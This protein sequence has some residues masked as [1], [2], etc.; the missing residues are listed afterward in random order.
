[1]SANP[2]SNFFTVEQ[3]LVIA[4]VAGLSGSVLRRLW[5]LLCRICWRR[6]SKCF[7]HVVLLK[8]ENSWKTKEI[9]DG[10]I[11]SRIRQRGGRV[12]SAFDRNAGR[13]YIVRT[14]R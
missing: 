9:N 4:L 7:C 10:L 8:E 6:E 14:S 3:Q 12:V 13:A 2:K 5:C 1:M 11:Y